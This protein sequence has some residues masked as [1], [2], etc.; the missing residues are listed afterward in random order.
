MTIK[1]HPMVEITPYMYTGYSCRN[2]CHIYTTKERL[3][4]IFQTEYGE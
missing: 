1:C 3:Y 4:P 2:T